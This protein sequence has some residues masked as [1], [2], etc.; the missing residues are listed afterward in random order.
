MLRSIK[1]QIALQERIKTSPDFLRSSAAFYRT[2]CGLSLQPC[3][4]GPEVRR[5]TDTR[6]GQSGSAAH[7]SRLNNA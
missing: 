6:R 4:S 1:S 2:F 7:T 3:D 5:S